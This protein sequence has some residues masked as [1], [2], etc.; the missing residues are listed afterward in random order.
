MTT[1]D[2]GRADRTS[3]NVALVAALMAQLN[4][5]ADQIAQSAPP[6][7]RRPVPTFNEYV[8]QVVAGVTPGSRPVYDTYW[9]RIRDNRGQQTAPATSDQHAVNRTWPALRRADRVGSGRGDGR[10]DF[11]TNRLGTWRWC[12]GRRRDQRSPAGQRW[13]T[14]PLVCS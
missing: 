5:T 11:M 6:A 13:R 3:A 14:R 8:P 10:G 7:A 9:R 1:P 4:I 12:R 2:A